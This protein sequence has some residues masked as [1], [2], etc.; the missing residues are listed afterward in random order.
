MSGSRVYLVYPNAAVTQ[1]GA[2]AACA[3][4]DGDLATVGSA[5]DHAVLSAAAGGVW[6]IW[7]GLRSR[8]GASTTN[9]DDFAWLS[10][11]QAPT[12]AAWGRGQPSGGESLCKAL[13]APPGSSCGTC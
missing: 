2:R 6:G 3:A 7:I 12:W 5:A 10:T 4:K 13:S 8:T 11:G 9:R 1:A